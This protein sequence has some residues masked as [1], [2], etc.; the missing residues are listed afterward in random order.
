MR[1]ITCQ[2]PR[3]SRE[4]D[5]IEITFRVR[6]CGGFDI[7]AIDGYEGGVMHSQLCREVAHAA[8]PSSV[9]YARAI[10]EADYD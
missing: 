10:D 3:T 5:E 9:Q 8:I 6:R 7:I 2:D 1:T 4:D